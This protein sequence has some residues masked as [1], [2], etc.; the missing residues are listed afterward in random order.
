MTLTEALKVVL[1]LTTAN[2]YKSMTCY[3]NTNEWQDVYHAATPNGK[4]AYVK[5]I[6]RGYAPVIQF[7]EK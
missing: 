7:K 6:L 4:V 3:G 1:T 5:F 2:F